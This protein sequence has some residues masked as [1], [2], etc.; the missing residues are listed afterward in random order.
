MDRI[1]S[2]FRAVGDFDNALHYRLQAVEGQLKYG[3]KRG[4]ATV[5]NNT[6][7]IYKDLGRY[8]E[9]IEMHKR[10]LA[11][12]EELGYERGMVYSYNNLGE[13]YRLS[14]DF[15]SAKLY[16]HKAQELATKLDNPMLLGA[17]NLYLGRIALAESRYQDAERFLTDA[18]YTYRRRNSVTRLAEGLTEQAN[19]AFAQEQYKKAETLYM[20]AI[21]YAQQSQK[22]VVLLNAYE[23]LSQ[24]YA[25]LNNY[26]SAFEMQ[27]RYQASRDSLFD[28]NSQQRIE[29]LIVQNQIQETQ[30]HLSFLKQQAQLT[31]SKLKHKIANRNLM[32]LGV[33]TLVALVG[34]FYSRRVHKRELALL[35]RSHAAIAEKE[36]KLS[37][38][39]WASGD[40]LW[41]WDVK[42]KI[43]SRENAG[44]L[45]A[46]PEGQV[47]PS[48]EAYRSFVHEED[49]D[50]LIAQLEAVKSNQEDAFE[51]SYRVKNKAGEWAWVQDKGKVVETDEV[52]APKKVAGIQHDITI[53][54]QQEADLVVLNTELEMRVKQ[55]T[56]DLVE[57]LDK[58]KVTQQSLVEAEKMAALGALVAG[59]AHEINTPLG[60][61]MTAITHLEA[62][63]AQLK[64]KIASQSLTKSNLQSGLDG[65]TSGKDIVL[66]GVE[67][68]IGLVQQFKRVSV[69]G[70][71]TEVAKAPFGELVETAFRCA[72]SN[73][74]EPD[75]IELCVNQDGEVATYLDP[76]MQVLELLLSNAIQHAKPKTA[77]IIHA[78]FHEYD[79]YFEVVI[80]DNGVGVEADIRNKIFE[81]FYT[82]MRHAGS[83]GLGLN[84][85]FNLVVQLL[86]GEIHCE[87]SQ[88]GGAKFRF[89]IA[90]NVDKVSARSLQSE[91]E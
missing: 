42:N 81:P 53:L 15:K 85:V 43:I 13:T 34:Y 87:A 64:D 61:A 6:A 76:L 48:W 12:K 4:Q 71:E 65:I 41:S 47:D 79:T 33:L 67:R 52:G 27:K 57:T 46:L 14:G 23:S 16:L 59:L 17:T 7:T 25:E 44:R 22:N 3:S 31:E 62:E 11:L 1:G 28:A 26:K 63:L 30:R 80:E 82:S 36:Q 51:V 54:K 91:S 77:L 39:L 2:T 21:D 8:D 40:V 83:V 89:S 20:E 56:H 29:M 72:K 68:A 86:G 88:L 66:K 35:S 69:S 75:N 5:L 55:R 74:G 37:L 78:A 9:A 70:T 58:L 19:L 50:R 32:I 24:M 45:D 38:A 10:S 60:T 90:K 84:I 18:M 49:F 73:N